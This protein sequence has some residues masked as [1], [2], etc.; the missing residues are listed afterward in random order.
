M[1]GAEHTVVASPNKCPHLPP[2]IWKRIL[3]YYFNF[4]KEIHSKRWPCLK[5]MRVDKLLDHNTI[6]LG[7]MAL[8][9]LYGNATVVVQT[10][11]LEMGDQRSEDLV[12]EPLCIAYPSAAASHWVRKLDFQFYCLDISILWKKKP[13]LHERSQVDW[14][15][16]L[17]NGALGFQ[18]LQRPRLFIPA[19]DRYASCDPRTLFLSILKKC[20]S[21][22]QLQFQTDRLEIEIGRNGYRTAHVHALKAFELC[23]ELHEAE[24]KLASKIFGRR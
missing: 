22:G 8:E 3:E 16:R 6:Y 21:H 2:E 12:N 4:P 14:L 19:A 11:N 7:S 10:I 17:A 5:T 18:S 23:C 1:E 13:T 15:S 24:V 20:L 9:A